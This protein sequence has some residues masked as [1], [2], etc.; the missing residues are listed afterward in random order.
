ME[1]YPVFTEVLKPPLQPEVAN[2]SYNHCLYTVQT[3]LNFACGSFCCKITLIW[4]CSS[5]S[6]DISSQMCW[7]RQ[8]VLAMSNFDV[9]NIIGNVNINGN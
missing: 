5:L 2:E 7:F 8:N 3:G 6:A 4:L 1:Y 9:Y